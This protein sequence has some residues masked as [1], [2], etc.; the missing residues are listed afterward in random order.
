MARDFGGS[1]YVQIANNSDNHI[2]SSQLTLAAW[3][4]ADATNGF[5]AA[6]AKASDALGSYSYWLGLE[7]GKV[8]LY[9]FSPG[10]GGFSGATNVSTGVWTHI[11]GVADGSN[12]TVYLNGVADGTVS[13][14]G[15]VP[16]ASSVP[17]RIGDQGSSGSET[18]FDGRIQEAAI[19]DVGLSAVEIAA[20]AAGAA[21]SLFRRSSLRAYYPLLG[22]T[23]EQDF[24]RGN[25]STTISGT[26]IIAHR[27]ITYGGIIAPVTVGA[28]PQSV[29]PT[30]ISTGEAFS[31]PT[32]AAGAVT[33]AP[34]A[35]S[36]A[37]AIGAPTIAVGG[38]SVSPNAIDSAETV[39]QA[40]VTSVT[41]LLP[42]AIASA[43]ALSSPSVQVGGV[44]VA[45]TAI[46]SDE[47]LGSPTVQAG[48][49]NVAPNSVGTVEAFGAP[50]LTT[51]G[52]SVLPD[53]IGSA[54]ALGSPTI[55]TPAQILLPTSIISAEAAG[56]PSLVTG[57]VQVQPASIESGEAQ[58]APTLLSGAVS[59]APTAITSGE[60]VASP[61]ISTAFQML[62]NLIAS[63]EALG[64][65]ALIVSSVTITLISIGSLESVPSLL[66]F[67]WSDIDNYPT[68]NLLRMP[69]YRNFIRP[70]VGLFLLELTMS[71]IGYV[72][73]KHPDAI[74][75]YVFD[76]LPRIGE[77]DSIASQ[78][79][80]ITPT[81]ELTAIASNTSNRTRVTL[82]GGVHERKYTLEITV[83]TSLGQRSVATLD[84]SVNRRHFAGA[85][86]TVS[87]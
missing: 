3:I 16:A 50:A 82:S 70:A 74:D 72:I 47:A 78:T 10:Y 27:A 73:L 13:R 83:T 26:S 43:E 80:A 77:A 45:P 65:P 29:S 63:G 36:S 48:T 59:I 64:T 55:V 69:T 33:V 4:Y 66:V 38:V 86:R 37:E 17:L 21:P 42:G 40:T 35:I 32:V 76:W 23:T 1:D 2:S 34:T 39:P 79:V 6:I 54:E 28:T 62:P 19:W 87:R 49:V 5:R 52:V 14:S 85:Q 44:N 24:A 81:G 58:G 15:N 46:A 41:T 57:G 61:T 18:G 75:D 12:W 71:N 60:A 22:T 20:L 30:S 7:N 8:T 51:G 31:N 56:A 68:R 9:D 84:V 11:A 67:R 25:P 53:A